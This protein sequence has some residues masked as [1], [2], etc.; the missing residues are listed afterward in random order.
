[1]FLLWPKLPIAAE[2]EY[3]TEI[4][5][6]APMAREASLMTACASSATVLTGATAMMIATAAKVLH[7]EAL[8]RNEGSLPT[9]GRGRLPAAVTFDHQ[10]RWI[11]KPVRASRA[12]NSGPHTILPSSWP[13]SPASP[14]AELSRGAHEISLLSNSV[15]PGPAAMPMFG[16]WANTTVGSAVSIRIA[17]SSHAASCQ[18][19]SGGRFASRTAPRSPVS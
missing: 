16:Q 6:V 19:S 12:E 7:M 11:Q 18:A 3:A 4:N 9:F 8:A 5:A 14:D 2:P 10:S 13:G 15:H 17:P 1:M